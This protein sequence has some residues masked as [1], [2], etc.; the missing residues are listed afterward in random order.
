MRLN[1][2]NTELVYMKKFRQKIGEKIGSDNR[3][4]IESA[5]LKQKLVNLKGEYSLELCPGFDADI[6]NLTKM[7]RSYGLIVKPKCS[8]D[9]DKI[10]KFIGQDNFDEIKK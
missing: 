4:Q 1:V 10:V 5:I 9:K 7:L 2:Q 6:N 8:L 3:D